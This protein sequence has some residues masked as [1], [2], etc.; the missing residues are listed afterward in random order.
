MVTR[1][2]GSAPALL[3][4]AA[5]RGNGTPGLA[6][7][8]RVLTG[9]DVA[10]RALNEASFKDGTLASVSARNGDPKQTNFE[11][12]AWLCLRAKRADLGT[13]GGA[14][15]SVFQGAT[16]LDA[17]RPHGALKGA[18]LAGADLAGTIF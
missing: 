11:N 10:R 17:H 9:H 1:R 4:P 5:S 3:C 6:P 13:D 14:S 8:G 15:R 18:D 16:P 12:S 2:P 7:E